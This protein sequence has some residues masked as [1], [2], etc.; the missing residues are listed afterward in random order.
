MR[1]NNNKCILIIIEF[2]T[3]LTLPYTIIVD[4][5]S[6]FFSSFLTACHSIIRNVENA[7]TIFMWRK[8][9]D[10]DVMTSETGWNFKRIPT[11][12]V[13]Q[14]MDDDKAKSKNGLII[15][16]THN[17][18]LLSTQVSSISPFQ[19]RIRRWRRRQQQNGTGT[20]QYV[21]SKMC[22]WA[23]NKSQHKISTLRIIR[24]ADGFWWEKKQE[25][26]NER[27]G[28]KRNRRWNHLVTGNSTVD[29]M[30]CTKK[31]WHDGDTHFFL[32]FVFFSSC[33]GSIDA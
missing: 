9:N 27:Q 31:Y 24:D 18:Y 5:P 1:A 17:V 3:P 4:I 16:P 12:G 7:Y 13:C 6:I 30:T 20:W 25:P 22:F 2:G 19:K 29:E 26:T 15:K 8:R 21:Y 33:F 23:L 14:T 10:N 11:I 32:L 28:E